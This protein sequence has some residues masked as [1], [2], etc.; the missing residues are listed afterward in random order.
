MD[1]F[2]EWAVHVDNQTTSDPNIL[3]FRI[4]DD[5]LVKQ[6]HHKDDQ[7]V[8]FDFN[9]QTDDPETLVKDMVCHIISHKSD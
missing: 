5:I 4:K 1:F 8:Q 9:I 2:N 6:D 7:T 3:Q